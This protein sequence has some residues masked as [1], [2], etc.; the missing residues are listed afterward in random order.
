M[1]KEIGMRSGQEIKVFCTG[2]GKSIFEE[3]LY[4]SGLVAQGCWSEMD[5]YDREAIKRFGELIV[6]DCISIVLKD[7][8]PQWDW[9]EANTHS[10]NIAV[11]LKNHFGV[12]E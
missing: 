5:E 3:L 9:T 11:D 12:E 6:Q 10:K 7:A 4:H 1:N 2:V 8:T